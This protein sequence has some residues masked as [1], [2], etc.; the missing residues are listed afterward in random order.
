M[1]VSS[2]SFAMTS[3]ICLAFSLYS[4][5]DGSTIVGSTDIALAWCGGQCVAM[6]LEAVRTGRKAGCQHGLEMHFES[7]RAPRDALNVA[8]VSIERSRG[9]SDRTSTLLHEFLEAVDT[10]EG[11]TAARDG[12][13][14][15]DFWGALHLQG[16]SNFMYIH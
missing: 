11:N 7:F 12:L 6:P 4:S 2:S 1:F 14:S 8:I 15:P 3:P 9:G 16:C 13:R 10:K 5:D